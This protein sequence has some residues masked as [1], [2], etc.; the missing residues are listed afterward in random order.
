MSN[1][2]RLPIHPVAKERSS[3]PSRRKEKVKAKESDKG[4][5]TVAIVNI[6]NHRLE[7]GSWKFMHVETSRNTHLKAEGNFEHVRQSKK[8]PI[9]GILVR[10]R[11]LPSEM[12][13]IIFSRQSLERATFRDKFPSLN[14]IQTGGKNGRSPNAPPYDQRSTEWNEEQEEFARHE[15]YNF[16]K[17]LSKMK[18]HYR[19]VHRTN[20]FR[21][22]VS[23]K[24]KT[25][26]CG[27]TILT[28]ERMHIVYSGAS[29]HMM[30]ISS[31][32]EKEKKTN[33]AK[34]WTIRPP[35]ALWS[36]THKQKSAS[37][38]LALFF[39]WTWWKI[40]HQCNR[41]EDYAM[42]LVIL[43]VAVRRNSQIIKK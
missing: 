8:W 29:L 23:T 9:E 11:K 19:N 31:S 28:K 12:R 21:S 37:R 15:P 5:V 27:L 40:Q 17:E 14:V 2:K 35:T 13:I 10:R 3:Y 6:A 30:G 1:G 42:N 4:K 36:Q 34:S 25:T 20:F 41:W 7:N 26:A 32:N 38:S 24:A 33:P 16:H 39:G 18:G 43:I 22:F